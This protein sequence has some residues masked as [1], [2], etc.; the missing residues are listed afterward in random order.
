MVRP[1]TTVCSGNSSITGLAIIIQTAFI[2][3]TGGKGVRGVTDSNVIEPNPRTGPP[4]VTQGL[5]GENSISPSPF[6]IKCLA[7][8]SSSK[9][10]TKTLFGVA[11]GV[12]VG[13][14]SKQC[15]IF[16]YMM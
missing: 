6:H 16:Y 2:M 3:A 12:R 15:R 10:T 11:V 14:I 8:T 1:R 9:W 5:G 4:F 7:L 13:T